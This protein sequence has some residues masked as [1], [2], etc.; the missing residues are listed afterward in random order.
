ME[1]EK[2]ITDY[3][4]RTKGQII[5]N[6]PVRG[7]TAGAVWVQTAEGN[8]VAKKHSP[9]NLDTPGLIAE[10]LGWILCTELGLRV[11]EAEVRVVE[12]NGED[13]FWLSRDKKHELGAKHWATTSGTIRNLDDLGC[14]LALDAVLF[15]GDRHEENLLLTPY[16][17]RPSNGWVLWV[18]DFDNAKI[19]RGEKFDQ[20]HDSV[21]DTDM[22]PGDLPIGSLHE[23]AMECAKEMEGWSEAFLAARL[24]EACLLAD[25]EQYFG[26]ILDNLTAR[27]GE[28]QSLA[29]SFL[30]QY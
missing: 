26:A 19:T 17:G 14:L 24:R 6:G 12:S 7:S 9:L 30:E 23:P 22:L 13:S 4:D 18:I 10:A 16:D 5:K 8:W 11:P 3:I 1:Q 28:A 2:L 15:N 25:D 21:P 20:P 29:K 27:C